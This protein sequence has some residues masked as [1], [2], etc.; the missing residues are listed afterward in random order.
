MSQWNLI[1]LNIL[2]R[3]FT[4]TTL[5]SILIGR[6]NVLKYSCPPNYSI[7]RALLYCLIHG[8]WWFVG[9]W[10]WIFVCWLRSLPFNTFHNDPIKTVKTMHCVDYLIQLIRLS[11]W[12]MLYVRLN[13]HSPVFLNK[14]IK[15]DQLKRFFLNW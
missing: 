8:D 1:S 10:W 14:N 11:F 2:Y 9:F 3:S 15:T 12:V 6:L 5:L 4:P 7:L 13:L